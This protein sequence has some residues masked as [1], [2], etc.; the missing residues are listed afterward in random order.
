MKLTEGRGFEQWPPPGARVKDN[1]KAEFEE[2][3]QMI[4]WILA[5][6]CIHHHLSARL[7]EG[8]QPAYVITIAVQ[9][10]HRVWKDCRMMASVSESNE[11]VYCVENGGTDLAR[12][13]YGKATEALNRST[14]NSGLDPRTSL[15]DLTISAPAN[16]AKRY[17]LESSAQIL[18]QELEQL[19]T[20]YLCQPYP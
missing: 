2:I 14:V 4:L 13:G 5:S 6:S 17:R 1:D 10:L 8:W 11:L 7:S 12:K 3:H 16:E 19:L 20:L 15:V 18:L 9:P